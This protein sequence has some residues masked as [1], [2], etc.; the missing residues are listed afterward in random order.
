MY[1]KTYLKVFVALALVEINALPQG[2][3][4]PKNP[5]VNEIFGVDERQGS[6]QPTDLSCCG[7]AGILGE[8]EGNGGPTACGETLMELRNSDAPCCQ[9]LYCGQYNLIPFGTIHVCKE[10]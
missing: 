3:G 2:V 7:K 1:L 4:N 5:E 10:Y 8:A 6:C 9:G